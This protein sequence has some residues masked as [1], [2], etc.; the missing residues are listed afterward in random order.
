FLE[1]Y[2]P[3]E[4]YLNLIASSAGLIMNTLRP[5]GYGNILMMMYLGKPVYFNRKNISLPDLDRAGLNWLPIEALSPIHSKPDL[6]NDD[7]VINFLSHEL[8]TNV[9]RSL[10][11]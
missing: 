6:I 4:E 5:Q 3:F 7:A 10:F 2:M 9:Y 11:C 8:L 1:R